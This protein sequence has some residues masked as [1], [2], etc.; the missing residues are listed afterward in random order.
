MKEKLKLNEKKVLNHKEFK[1][2]LELVPPI[3]E[4]LLDFYHSRYS[5]AMKSLDQI[6]VY[7]SP[8]LS[9]Y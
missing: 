8:S 3:R 1:G 6:M 5:S 2:L 4:L 9:S 7:F